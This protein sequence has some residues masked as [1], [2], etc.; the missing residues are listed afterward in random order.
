MI[1]IKYIFDILCDGAPCAI[2]VLY[3]LSRPSVDGDR[4]K[5][6]VFTSRS[7]YVACSV[8]IFVAV[9]SRLMRDYF[10]GQL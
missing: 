8:I 9:L 2:A 7:F 3:L 5:R 4:K 6:S 10:F 1:Y